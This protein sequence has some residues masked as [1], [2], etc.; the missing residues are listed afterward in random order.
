MYSDAL[1]AFKT[2]ILT[3]IGMFFL[4]LAQLSF[5]DG[6]PFWDQ[7]DVNSN[8]QCIYSF[9]SPDTTAYNAS[10]LLPY[11]IMIYLFKYN[12]TPYVV[13]NVSAIFLMVILWV[14]IYLESYVNG[15]A[16]IYQNVIGQLSGF[17]YLVF[18]LTFDNEI[19]RYC[20]KAGFI[21][22]SSR[23]RKFHIFFFCAGCFIFVIAYFSA[24]SDW[25]M[26]LDWI[27]NANLNEEI[28]LK[29]FE[30]RANNNLGMN[31]TFNN[32]AIL[33]VLIGANF[34]QSFTLNFVKPLFWSHSQLWKR[35]LRAIIGTG[36]AYGVFL[37]TTLLVS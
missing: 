34:G 4:V 14:W 25:R 13:I 37:G 10:F 31:A 22:R 11:V 29:L 1:L 12:Q 33:F 19:H 16:Y 9:S 15:T 2:M 28:C 5:K 20:E 21:V 36:M 23:S 3:T 26:P 8:G 6:R 30:N 18:C 24:L 27:V 17:V 7:A 32:S 35:L